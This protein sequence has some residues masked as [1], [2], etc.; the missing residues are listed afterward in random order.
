MSQ[1]EVREIN[2]FTV[3]EGTPD[4]LD[5]DGAVLRVVGLVALKSTEEQR[6]HKRAKDGNGVQLA[7]ELAKESLRVVNDKPVNL[8]DG[9]A[10][11]AWAAAGPQGRALI[12]NGYA[13]IHAPK[14][15][16]VASFLA[17][18]KRKVGG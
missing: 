5:P 15:E 17:S 3:P 10:N 14:E 6:A 12:L 4:A 8:M 1:D 13:E 11:K 18:R 2:E 9:S 16:S 7:Y